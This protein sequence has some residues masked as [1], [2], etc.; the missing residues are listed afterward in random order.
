MGY[1]TVGADVMSQHGRLSSTQPRSRCYAVSTVSGSSACPRPWWQFTAALAA[2]VAAV[3]VWILLLGHAEV[4]HEPVAPHPA[5]VLVS[6]LGGEFTI[7]SNHAHIGTPSVAHHEAFMSAVLPNAPVTTVAAL[8][9]VVAVIG[10]VGLFGRHVI[11]GGRGPPR[12]IAGILTGQ[13]L[14][15]RLCSSRR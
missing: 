9:V 5:H 1:E 8:S 7:S 15:T 4:R 13:E 3:A 6:S 10:A 12:G 11:L 2:A 14:L